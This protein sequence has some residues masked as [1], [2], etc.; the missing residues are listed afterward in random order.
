M[1][2]LLS[3][4]DVYRKK[5]NNTKSFGVCFGDSV[6]FVKGSKVK[7]RKIEKLKRKEI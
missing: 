2:K 6:L 1:L 3:A 5:T 4:I 7:R